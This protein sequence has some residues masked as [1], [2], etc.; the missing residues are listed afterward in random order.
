MKLLEHL[1][2]TDAMLTTPA[3]A[4]ADFAAWNAATNYAV[5]TRVI[6]INVHRIYENRIAG[7]DAGLPE[8]TPARWLD[9]GPTNRWAMFD[10]AMGTRTLSPGNTMTW[11]ITLPGTVIDSLWLL[12]VSGATVRVQMVNAATTVYDRTVS[13]ENARTATDYWEW[14]FTLP[15]RRTSVGFEDLPPYGGAVIT[16]TVTDGSPVS[17]G[18][19]LIG[20]MFPIGDSEWGAKAGITD[21][22]RRTTDAFGTTTVVQRGYA[23]R[24]SQ[25]VAIDNLVFDEVL[26]RLA[27]RRARPS[28]YI[29]A[30]GLYDAFGVYG[31]F[32]S[33]EVELSGPTESL[34]SLDI[35]G[36]I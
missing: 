32:R 15:L 14:F 17:V 25:V 1:T 10:E 34:C 18:T 4:E 19:C 22:S 24:T 5:A 33:L 21:Y 28:L 30:A 13:L 12:D 3:V 26:R 31:F 11:S 29:G 9:V 6:R 27:A 20:S 36:M 35:E 16:I 2:I 23:R 8:A 7:V